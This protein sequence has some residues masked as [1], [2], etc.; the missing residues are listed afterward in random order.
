MR[1][2]RFSEAVELQVDEPRDPH[3]S[4]EKFAYPTLTYLRTW[5]YF[6]S[7]VPKDNIEGFN[8]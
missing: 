2:L 8:D 1:E 3:Y 6:E 4:P 7:C 5:N